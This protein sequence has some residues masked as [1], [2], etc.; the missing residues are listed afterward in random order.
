MVTSMAFLA[1]GKMMMETENLPK[2]GAPTSAVAALRGHAIWMWM[3]K[4][5][6]CWLDKQPVPHF[7]GQAVMT[8]LTMVE[9]MPLLSRFRM[10]VA[11][12]CGE[13]TSVVMQMK[14]R[15]DLPG[16]K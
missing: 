11:M 4:E 16:K 10:Q 15:L 1:N 6:L 3:I 9:R 14:K 13:H 8:P 12:H 7:I 5:T 2:P